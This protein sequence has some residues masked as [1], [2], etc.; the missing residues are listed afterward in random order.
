MLE[1]VANYEIRGIDL[2]CS[3]RSYADETT[4]KHNKSEITVKSKI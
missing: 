1:K 2:G 3:N 4:I